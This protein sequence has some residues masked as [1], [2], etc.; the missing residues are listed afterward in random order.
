MHKFTFAALSLAAALAACGSQ[1]E[2]DGV[3]A[4]GVNLTPVATENAAATAGNAAASDAVPAAAIPAA[5]L[6]S[7]AL[8]PG[9]CTTEWGDAKGLLTVTPS[10]LRFYE[11]RGKLGAVIESSPTRIAADFDFQGEGEEWQRRMTLERDGEE[12]VR[13]ETGEGAATEPFRYQRCPAWPA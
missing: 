3:D 1:P 4:A 11:S 6:G 10:E 13:S 7:W 12:L 9:D 8:V 2:E 5:L